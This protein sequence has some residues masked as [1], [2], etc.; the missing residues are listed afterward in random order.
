VSG[1][2]SK[3]LCSG[4]R[5]TNSQEGIQINEFEKQIG[6][7]FQK[8]RDKKIAHLYFLFPP[9]RIAGLHGHIPC[10]VPTGKAPYDAAGFFYDNCGSS[11]GVEL[12]QTKE[13]EG[14][15]PLVAP[16]AKGNG[17][18]YHQLDALVTMYK[19][20]GTALLLYNN[21]GE[22]GRLSGSSLEAVKLA[23][24]ASLKAEA[25]N[26]EVAKGSRSIAWGMFEKVA[27][28]DD[29]DP[30]WMPKLGVCVRRAGR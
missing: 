9:M 15:L 24:D 25:A 17:L 29:G 11:I 19:S 20:G 26:K 13:H 8:Y 28:D 30:L 12:K 21:G 14:R 6:A 22:V 5:R 7:T 2:S 4:C 3:K 23:Y 27:Q 18:Q 16:K 1:I 10:Y